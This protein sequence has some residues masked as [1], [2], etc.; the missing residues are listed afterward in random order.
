MVKHILL[1]SYLLLLTACVLPP[2]SDVKIPTPL[3]APNMGRT[4]EISATPAEEKKQELGSARFQSTPTY[5]LSLSSHGEVVKDYVPVFPH[6]NPSQISVEALPLPTFIN[7][8][9]G[10]LLGLSFDIDA[11]LQTKKDLV[12]LRVVEPQTP[13]QLYKLANQVLENY[14]VGLA[15]QDNLLRFVPAAS[16]INPVPPLLVTGTT[17]PSVPISHRP[18]FQVVPLKVLRNTQIAN[19]LRQIYNNPKLQM[20][21]DPER[22]AIVLLGTPELIRNAVNIIGFL[23]QPF[24]R[25]RHSVR[26]E[27]VFLSAEDLNIQL[28]NVLASE[29]FAVTGG[30]SA[31]GSIIMFPLK[32]SNA[33]IAF[34]N[35]ETVIEHIKQWVK[36]LD[37]PNSNAN[38]KEGD[39][40]FFYPVQNTQAENLSK[41]LSPLLDGVIASTTSQTSPASTTANDQT[42]KSANPANVPNITNSTTTNSRRLVV[43]TNRNALLYQGTAESWAYLL[44]I[45]KQM[46]QPPKLT[47]IEVTLAEVTLNDQEQF[48][49]E[50]LAKGLDLGGSLGGTLSTMALSPTTSGLTYTIDNA[51]Q[52]RAL[53][54]AF[55]SNSRISIL[56]SPRVMVKSGES[57]TINVGTEVPIV[58]SQSSD[59]SQQSDSTILQQIQ[60]RTTGVLLTVKPIVHAGNRIDLDIKQEVSN[61]TTNE[62]SGIDSPSILNRSITTKLTLNDGGSV[63]LGGLISNNNNVGN[64][65]VPVLKDIPIVGSLFKTESSSVERTELIAIIVPYVINNDSEAQEITQS[66]RERLS[67]ETQNVSSPIMPNTTVVPN[68][69]QPLRQEIKP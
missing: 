46:D 9:Y 44:P 19:W 27:P 62:F 35:D 56:S 38:K 18:I 16:N 42:N 2:A 7:E 52:T 10:N 48:G 41:V 69:I 24:M 59:S 1:F 22:N 67:V 68:I 23:D 55:A 63:L 30:A 3:R 28:T 14:G 15:L 58:T 64:S 40:L 29:G 54:G 20:L 47:L 51:G 8:V 32:A 11:S 21:E 39:S 66:F 45:L 65:G 4:G 33:L 31:G 49:I 12:T 5:A 37:A 34:A 60:Y 6:T 25:S 50:W 61:A 17:L 26:I 53:L 36:T 43:D 57:A 13:V